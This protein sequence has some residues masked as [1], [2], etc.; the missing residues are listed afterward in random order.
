[1]PVL[2]VAAPVSKLERE[3][4][5]A[6][7]FG[8]LGGA[9]AMVPK[10]TPSGEVSQEDTVKRQ[11]GEKGGKGCEKEK[12]GH[13]R[14]DEKGKRWVVR[15]VRGKEEE[16]GPEE[17]EPGWGPE[18]SCS[19]ERQGGAARGPESQGKG[20]TGRGARKGTE[21]GG[22]RCVLEGRCSRRRQTR[23]NRGKG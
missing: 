9:Q 22:G 1:M 4:Q 7:L 16:P 23:M 17:R 20:Q 11:E 12:P 5:G 3:N 18:G 15:R 10:E 19:K 2:S 13:G 6:S 8:P 14:E 21:S